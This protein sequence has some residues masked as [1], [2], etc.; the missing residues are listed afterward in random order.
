MPLSHRNI[1]NLC[2]FPC[3]ERS[4]GPRQVSATMQGRL[5]DP[6]GD[7]ARR[8]RRG[9][10]RQAARH[11]PRLRPQGKISFKIVL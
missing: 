6:E 7:R 11:R 1:L 3:S 9:V 8:L 10:R 5:R 2:L 4:V